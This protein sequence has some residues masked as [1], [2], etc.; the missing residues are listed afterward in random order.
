MGRSTGKEKAPEREPL[1][2]EERVSNLERVARFLGAH[3][4][5]SHS[6]DTM[7]TTREEPA[8]EET[9]KEEEV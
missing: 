1:T 4:G 7:L 2:T 6:V 8:E 5:L 9:G 3:H